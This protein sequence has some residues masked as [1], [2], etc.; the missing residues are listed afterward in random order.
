MPKKVELPDQAPKF[1]EG[2]VATFIVTVIS[3]AI[4]SLA[5]A[6]HVYDAASISV[7]AVKWAFVLLAGAFAFGMAMVPMS[8]A[9]A[10]GTAIEGAS[11]QNAILGIVLMV[12]LIDGALQVHAAHF[13]MDALQVKGVSIWYLVIG[14]CAFQFAMFFIRGALH[15]ATSEISALIEAREERLAA[16]EA[17]KRA[18]YNARR[19]E[20]Y[21]EKKLQI[22]R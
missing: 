9:R 12:M 1:K 4:S 10:H 20:Q 21:A 17:R 18:E 11:A 2:H 3:G 5:L 19:R 14:A 8:L 22:V 13:I 16:I 6:Y 7:E 15:Q